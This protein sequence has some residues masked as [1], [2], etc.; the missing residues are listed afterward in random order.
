MTGLTC[1]APLVVWSNNTEMPCT[2]LRGHDGL[3]GATWGRA[4]V[5]WDDRPRC[6]AWRTGQDTETKHV[7]LRPA[8]DHTGKPGEHTAHMSFELTT[9]QRFFWVGDARE[10]ELTG[11]DLGSKEE[12]EEA[13]ERSL[14][15]RQPHKLT[16]LPPGMP[17]VTPLPPEAREVM[18]R[19]KDG[20][21]AW[22]A[23]EERE[24]RAPRVEIRYPPRT[25]AQRKNRRAK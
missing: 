25:R 10:S 18:A 8:I 4:Y 20:V 3:H 19:L 11:W 22:Y 12:Y 2:R 1:F 9:G 5:R 15:V 24:G 17:E 21:A 7:C 16:V 6:R 13:L 23:E 14:S